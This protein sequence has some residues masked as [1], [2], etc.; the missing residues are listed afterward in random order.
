MP[1]GE[2]DATLAQEAERSTVPPRPLHI[3]FSWSLQER[4]ARFSGDGAARFAPPDRARLDLFG[5]RGETV[6][7]AALVDFELRLPPGV[8]NALLPPPALLWSALGIFR[9]PEGATLV[10]T[11]RDGDRHTL[12]YEAGSER[13]R[14][15]LRAGRLHSVE[16]TGPGQGRRTIELGD[17]GSHGVP[18]AA[19]YRD[20]PA[21]TELRLTLK[22]ANEVDGFPP[23]TWTPGR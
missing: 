6:L 13:W 19:T 10:A 5:P 21:F 7:A 15:A 23:E 20:W 11:E 14:F 8:Q 17:A 3:V 12:V 18:A 16:W 2:V 1:T 4:E 22:E 9:A